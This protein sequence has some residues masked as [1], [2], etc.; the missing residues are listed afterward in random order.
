MSFSIQSIIL[1]SICSVL[2][3]ACARDSGDES[4]VP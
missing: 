3:V 2:F 1:F 4:Q